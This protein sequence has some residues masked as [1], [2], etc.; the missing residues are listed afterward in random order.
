M[1]TSVG[2]ECCKKLCFKK[3]LDFFFSPP[4][5]FLAEGLVGAVLL[6]S[7][8]ACAIYIPAAPDVQGDRAKSKRGL[9]WWWLGGGKN[10]SACIMID[11]SALAVGWGKKKARRC[12]VSNVRGPVGWVGFCGF[13]GGDGRVRLE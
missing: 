10:P 12:H 7:F 4:R 8:Q 1:Q 2:E 6:G 9:G 3:M 13:W 5:P 11:L